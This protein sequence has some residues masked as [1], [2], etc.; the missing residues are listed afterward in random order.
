MK[1]AEREAELSGRV[2]L[3]TGAATGIGWAAAQRF[4]ALGA[5]V[6]IADIN[7]DKAA[8]RAGELGTAHAF[9]GVDISKGNRTGY[10][11]ESG[12]TDEIFHSPKEHLT[13][14]YVSG[15]FS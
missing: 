9:F 15:Q 7:A 6:L 10:L 3:I 5:R 12:P 8:V 13:K 2:V 14:E 1:R 4:A 11:V